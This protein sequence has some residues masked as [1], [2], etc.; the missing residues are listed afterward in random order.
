VIGRYWLPALNIALAVFLL[1]GLAAPLLAVLGF[2]GAADVVYGGYALTCHQWAF[3]SFFVFGD[4]LIYAREQLDQLGL[5]PYRFVGQPGLGWKL[6]FCERDLA[7]YVGLLAAGVS[8]TR[9]RFAPLGLLAYAIAILPMALDGGSQ[10]LGWRESTWELR[11]ATGLVFGLA[12]GWLLYPRVDAYL[13]VEPF[14][15]RYAA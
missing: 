1:G 15:R 5:D 4:Q 13:R 7:I 9:R 8:F 6:A 12:S 14:A 11:V 10:L 2:S 3:R